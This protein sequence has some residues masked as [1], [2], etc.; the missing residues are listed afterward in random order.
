MSQAIVRLDLKILREMLRLPQDIKIAGVRSDPDNPGKVI[1][2][3]ESKWLP[4][5]RELI[6]KYKFQHTTIINFDGWEI[7][8]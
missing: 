6:A 3:I 7:C 5:D 4:S 2:D 8:D 1:L